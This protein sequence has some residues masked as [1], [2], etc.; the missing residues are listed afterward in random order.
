MIIGITINNILR[1]HLSQLSRIYELTTGEVPI[2]PINPFDLE[3]SFPDKSS[4]EIVSD[5]NVNHKNLDLAYNDVDEKFNVFE[6]MYSEASFEI[7]GRAEESTSGVI[8]YLNELEKK[9]KC[10]IVLLK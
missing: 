10:K 9:L 8:F 1:D 7:F 2:S 5:F 3:T 4:I 6:C